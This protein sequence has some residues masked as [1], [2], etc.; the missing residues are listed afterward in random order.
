MEIARKLQQAGLGNSKK[1]VVMPTNVENF[2]KRVYYSDRAAYALTSLMGN[3]SKLCA[4]APADFN[5]AGKFVHNRTPQDLL[6]E[7]CK[8]RIPRNSRFT[9]DTVGAKKGNF[10]KLHENSDDVSQLQAVANTRI[11]QVSD[12]EELKAITKKEKIKKAFI[13]TEVEK[14]KAE[15]RKATVTSKKAIRPIRPR[16]I[17]P[18]QALSNGESSSSNASKGKGASDKTQEE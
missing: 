11:A 3:R 6:A 12:A 10:P 7:L 18:V 9:T 5:A 16:P 13:K 4:F 1:W 2:P 8:A 14:L 17:V 15:H